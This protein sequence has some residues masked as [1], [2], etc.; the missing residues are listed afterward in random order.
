[1]SIRSLR[2][3]NI[4]YR[5]AGYKVAESIVVGATIYFV[6][7]SISQ[8]AGAAGAYLLLTIGT[9]IAEAVIGDYADNLLLGLL[10]LLFTAVLSVPD[11]WLPVMILGTLVGCWLLI[12]G[13]HHLRYGETR[14]ELSVPYSH[15]GG[16]ITGILRVFFARILEPFRLGN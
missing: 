1:M 3:A 13:F 15:D 11:P 7:E 4:P 9:A 16:P 14:A 10:F 5:L 12:D 6:S 8:A 2:F